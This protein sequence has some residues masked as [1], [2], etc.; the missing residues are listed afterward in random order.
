MKRVLATGCFVWVGARLVAAYLPPVASW[1]LAAVFVSV[2]LVAMCIK[3]WKYVRVLSVIGL[4]AVLFQMVM[5][6]LFV[7]PVQNLAGQT[8]TATVI[9]E[10]VDAGFLENSVRGQF[11]VISL[12]GV[13]LPKSKQFRVICSAFPEVSQGD[14]VQTTL[15][16][17]SLEEDAYYYGYLADGVLLQAEAS[18]SIQN[19]GTSH[20][21]RFFMAELQHKLSMTCRRYLPKT[22]GSILA[23]MAVG[24]SRYLTNET[25]V[26]YRIAG[27]THLLVVSGQHLT[28][29]CGLFAG[30]PGRR[31]ARV[32]AAASI[33]MILFVMALNGFSPSIARAGVAALI[34]YIGWFFYQPADG[35]TFLGVAAV[36]LTLSRC[37]AVCDLGLQLS[38]AATFGVLIAD[39]TAKQWK[40]V[41]A[42]ADKPISD[43]MYVVVMTLLITVFA[44]A[45][46]L[47]I[48]LL[49]NL[50][51]SGVAILTN[52][53]VMPLVGPVVI[54]GLLAAFCGL[55]PGLLFAVRFFLLLAGFFVKLINQIVAFTIVLPGAQLMLPKGYTL[56]V[57]AILSVLIWLGCRWNCRRQAVVFASGLAVTAVLLYS[58]LQ[59]NVVTLVTAGDAA[60]PCAV[61]FYQEQSM[62][63]FQGGESNRQS[64]MQTLQRY[65]VAEPNVWVDLRSD[66]TSLEIQA[67]QI[68]TAQ[69]L[70][71]KQ[72]ETI[73]FCDIIGTIVNAGTANLAVL[74]I[75]GYRIGIIQGTLTSL[76]PLQLDI[77]IAGSKQPGT[78]EAQ[79]IVSEKE[80]DWHT[81]YQTAS[82]AFELIGTN[83]QIRMGKAVQIGG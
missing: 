27:I 35:L 32:R 71:E 69:Q 64:V 72:G 46:T 79:R 56:F 16:F 38:F 13:N 49:N 66:P 5:Y 20:A 18:S 6:G 30:C 83:I 1:L 29:L 28:L 52:L 48:Q 73:A 54:L 41:R 65:G 4:A 44:S 81:Q 21:L 19:V 61:V 10:Q 39:L 34:F 15:S 80:Y 40:R 60:S 7:K 14:V 31:Y 45:F 9:A 59:N 50:P 77:L 25:K 36:L 67:E 57:V 42:Q 33:A 62:V 82:F 74:Q 51:V 26:N 70:Q 24:D 43:G 3:P 23:A 68:I 78:V 8:A 76:V 17:Q 22:E 58:N 37:Y 47:P 53:L 2:F 75:D 63:L 12:N 55:I 11:T